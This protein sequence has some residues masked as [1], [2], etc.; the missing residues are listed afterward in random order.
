MNRCILSGLLA[1]S[2]P[3]CVTIAGL[4]QDTAVILRAPATPLVVHDPYFSIWSTGYRLTDGPTK[5]WT[6][7]PQ[8]LNGLVRV[9]H[10][11]YRFLGDAAGRISA[12][13]E[14]NRQITH[15]H[16]SHIAKYRN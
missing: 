12:L 14:T 1:I 7:V 11:T 2:F 4:G 6:G 9:D 13:E 3:C 10:K 16:R 8:E 5:H 15:P